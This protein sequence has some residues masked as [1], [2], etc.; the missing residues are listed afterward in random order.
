MFL[1]LIIGLVLTAAIAWSIGGN[2]TANCVDSVVGARVI[3]VRKAIM[4]FA[5]GQFL[6]AVIQGYM[7]MKTLG[8]GIVANIAI[9]EAMAVAIAAFTWITIATL[10]KA[11]ISTTHSI[12]GAIIGI[13]IARILQGRQEVINVDIVIR[14]ILSWVTSPLATMSLSI[15]L[16]YIFLKMLRERDINTRIVK[17]I[18]IA[19][20]AFSAYSFGAN[21]VGNATGVYVTITSKYLGLPDLI[22]MRVLAIFAATFI[23]IGGF[24][25]GKR[26][27]ETLAFKIT[28]LDIPMALAAETA[29]ALTVWLFTTIPYFL[30]GYGLPIST[31]YATAG[32]I[33]G[34]GIAKYRGLSGVNIKMI[35]F[36]VCAWILTLPLTASASIA[37]YFLLKIFIGDAM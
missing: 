4:I 8:K 27:I 9:V 2:D 25:V 10:L 17:Y 13:G 24:T 28:R 16:Y 19:I 15:P 30:F 29:N 3:E 11:P 32:S 18:L 26:V 12:V 7:V 31:S 21:D 36:I 34:T 37:I 20:S 6:G 35:L 1:L 33:I 23:A 14:I 5:L 22:T